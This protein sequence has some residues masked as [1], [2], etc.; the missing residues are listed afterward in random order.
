MNPETNISNTQTGNDNK[1]YSIA[2]ANKIYIIVNG[3]AVNVKDVF[4][5]ISVVLS[6]YRDFFWGRVHIDRDVTH[7]LL[8]FCTDTIKN[9]EDKV[10]VVLGSAGM[11]KSVV[12]HDLLEKLNKKDHIGVLA[13]K[14]DRVVNSDGIAKNIIS[15][16]TPL[17]DLIRQYA[18]T[19]ERFVLLVDQIDALSQSMSNDRRAI[20]Y[21]DNL[22]QQVKQIPNSKIV[23]SC[24]PYDM[25]YDPTLEAYSKYKKFELVKL[26]ETE[27]MKVL[28]DANIKHPSIGPNM[29]LFL[30]VPLHLYLYCLLNDGAS[31][32]EDITLQK[33]YD[34]I[35]SEYIVKRSSGHEL[36]TNKIIEFLSTLSDEMFDKQS[37]FVNFRKYE[38]K[39]HSE[40]SYLSTN[41]VINIDDGIIQ[42]FHQSFFDYVYARMLVESGK[43]LTKE[44]NKA[45]QGLFIRQR[46]KQILTYEREVDKDAYIG[47]LEEIFY[48]GRSYRYHIKMLVLTTIGSYNEILLCEKNFIKD[49]ILKDKLLAKVLIESIYSRSWFQYIVQT[50]YASEAIRDVD[51]DKIKLILELCE[52]LENK[53]PEVVLDY[54]NNV[55]CTVSDNTI[56]T[57]IARL[58]D[59]TNLNNFTDLTKSI[60]YK[61]NDPN[62]EISMPNYLR[63]M[64]TIDTKFVVEELIKDIELAINKLDPK[65]Y[66]SRLNVDYKIRE[67]YTHNSSL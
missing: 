43:S 26:N 2:T 16:A 12:M 35:W 66:R 38:N 60:Y 50:D 13:I 33:M 44:L 46:V 47:H 42:F 22:I 21:Q 49:N 36:D 8:V 14:A 1:I 61:V 29:M 24:R 34:K 39:Y 63:I 6:N 32:S 25:Q 59:R 41:G 7:S 11:G 54:V 37:L 58:I 3:T 45:H 23:V 56:R 62:K 31:F 9:D 4:K 5:N 19:V 65:D 57:N 52:R 10:A 51:I 17:I 30:Q 28:D 15:D 67:V 20:N 27:V 40:M 64:T 55:M 18:S 48:S 53:E